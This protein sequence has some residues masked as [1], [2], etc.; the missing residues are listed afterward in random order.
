MRCGVFI[1]VLR[2]I[3]PPLAAH[4]GAIR[5]PLT[6]RQREMLRLA[7]EGLSTGEIAT[8]Q[9]SLAGWFEARKWLRS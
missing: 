3:D 2:V 7:R 6:D 8:E 5:N 1:E 9:I 4:R